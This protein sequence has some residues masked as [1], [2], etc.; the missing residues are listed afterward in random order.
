MKDILLAQML[1]LQI[2]RSMCTQAGSVAITRPDPDSAWVSARRTASERAND[3]SL[4]D[5]SPNDVFPSD[6]S[7][8]DASP[9]GEGAPADPAPLPSPVHGQQN[10]LPTEDRFQNLHF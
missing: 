4:N 6:V 9:S 8:N 1:C 7:L 10:G 3:V 5:V 2:P